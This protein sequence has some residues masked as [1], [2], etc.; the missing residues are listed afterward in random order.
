MAGAGNRK[1]SQNNLNYS[2]EQV[3]SVC[4]T[5]LG[6]SGAGNRQDPQGNLNYTW[7]EVNEVVAL[8]YGASVAGNRAPSIGNL[9]YSW[10]QVNQVVSANLGETF[11]GGDEYIIGDKITIDGIEWT[12]IKANPTGVAPTDQTA[13]EF[14]TPT[15]LIFSVTNNYVVGD[16]IYVIGNVYNCTSATT[17]GAAEDY[18]DTDYWELVEAY[19]SAN[20]PY[21]YH[22]AV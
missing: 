7:E 12:C 10:A 14:W 6:I 21:D 8:T 1:D 11:V 3:N 2:W 20:E 4:N 13:G 5:E 15:L 19:E 18:T 16:D 17:E 9:M 22:V